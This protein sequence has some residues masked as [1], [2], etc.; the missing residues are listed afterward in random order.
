MCRPAFDGVRTHEE[1]EEK[2]GEERKGRN[3]EKEREGGKEGEKKGEKSQRLGP[4]VKRKVE[5]IGPPPPST[6]Y[7]PNY[8][9]SRSL[10]ALKEN[11]R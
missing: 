9:N 11:R 2:E 7:T 10:Y 1:E 5:P 4:S 3:E 6:D 8:Y